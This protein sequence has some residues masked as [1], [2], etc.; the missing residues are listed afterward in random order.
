MS[1]LISH[2]LVVKSLSAQF[3]ITFPNYLK[4][5]IIKLVFQEALSNDNVVHNL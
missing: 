2:L 4:N 1:Y 3:K 5:E